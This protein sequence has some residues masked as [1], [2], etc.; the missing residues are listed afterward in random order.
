M[1]V[2]HLVTGLHILSTAKALPWIIRAKS[3]HECYV[4]RALL[5]CVATDPTIAKSVSQV[6]AAEP[7]DVS[8]ETLLAAIAVG[9]SASDVFSQ[10][11]SIAEF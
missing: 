8:F 1:A 9:A 10:M 2:Q 11:K 3:V 6:D 5:S 7:S 4:A